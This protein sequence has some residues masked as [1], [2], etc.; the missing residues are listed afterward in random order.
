[1]SQSVAVS[2]DGPDRVGPPI[3]W[4]PP[5]ARRLLQL[6]LA[7]VWLLDGVLQLQPFFFTSGSDGF[8]GMLASTAAGNPRGVARSII[9]NASVVD[10]HTVI[11]NSA[12][13]LIQILLG[14]GIAWRATLKPA[15][16]ASIVWS[17]AVWWF[18]EG[19]GRVLAGAGTPVGGGPGAVL[20]YALLAVLLWPT[21]R[22]GSTAP[23]V[24]ARAV[25][26]RAAK[27]VWVAAWAGLAV[28]ALLGSG[29]SPQGLHDLVDGLIPG[30][31]GWLQAIDRHAGSL[32][33]HEGLA[34]AVGLAA[35]CAIVALGVFLP[36]CW[37]RATLVL[38]IVTALVVW[39][40][41]QDFGTILAG[42]ATDPNSGPLLVLLA[43]A[44][45]P[46]NR[47][48]AIDPAAVST[49][50]ALPATVA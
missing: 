16:V 7:T 31:P 6:A 5:D 38:A 41:G 10:H 29:R 15:L 43:L 39:V 50:V 45:W 35:C 22:S 2:S 37:A 18:G 4:R 17:L 3:P 32:I 26:G 44:Y 19:L 23:F 11:T 42:G 24:A 46:A 40:V 1:M 27:V 30:E 12:F 13:A 25:G 34:V 20:F 36:L 14:F 48:G 21:D 9:W 8:S 49:E 47:R 28:L 33:S